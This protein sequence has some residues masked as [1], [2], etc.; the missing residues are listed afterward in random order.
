MPKWLP[1]FHA[2]SA[3]YNSHKFSSVYFRTNSR[4][5]SLKKGISQPLTVLT[6]SIPSECSYLVERHRQQ[7]PSL[8]AEHLPQCSF[9]PSRRE[10][11]RNLET[12]YRLVAQATPA[13]CRPCRSLCDA[14]AITSSSI[15]QRRWWR[16]RRQQQ[17]QQQ[18]QQQRQQRQAEMTELTTM[19]EKPDHKEPEEPKIRER[20]TDPDVTNV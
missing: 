2:K 1:A 11:H 19:T 15:Q 10:L 18:Q 9:V 12:I 16:W 3:L 20:Y 17:Q 6:F 5:T 14:P 7:Q 4:S 8:A 13:A